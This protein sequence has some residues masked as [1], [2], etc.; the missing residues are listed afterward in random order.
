MTT[1]AAD[2]P[3]NGFY[4][5]RHPSYDELLPHW[6]FCQEAYLGG[7]DWFE[8]NLFRFMKEGEQE[9]KDRKARAIRIN[10]T[11]ETV[12]LVQKYLF[13][14]PV[15]RD[16]EDASSTLRAF[17][18]KSMRSGQGVDELMRLVSTSNSITGRI[19]LVVDNSFPSFDGN[20]ISRL[21]A[22]G[23]SGSIYA[24]IVMPQDILDYAWSDDDGELLWIKLREF[25]RDDKDPHES[26]GSIQERVRL[27]T[28]DS[29]ELYELFEIAPTGAISANKETEKEAR[30]IDSG[31]HGLGFVPV[32]LCDHS[33]TDHPFRAPGLVDDI[34]YIDRQ[35][36]NYMSDLDAIIQDQ[37]FSQLVVPSQ[38]LS[39]D[40]KT[41]RD[42][43]I[44]MGTNRIFSYD[45]GAGSNAKPE[46][47]SP[48]PKQAG[49]IT[50]T[51]NMLITQIYSTVGLAGERTKQDNAI[52]I[53]NSSGVAKAYDFQRVNSL[54]LAKA[55][56]LETA[57]N[58][59]VRTVLAWAGEQMP[60]ENLVTYPTTFD[61]ASLN[62]EL[63][64]A[65]ALQKV[66]APMPIRRMHMKKLTEKLMPQ[67]TDA[68][69]EVLMSS[70]DDW[71]DVSLEE[72]KAGAIVAKESSTTTAQT[73]SKTV[74]ATK[75]QGSVTPDTKST[76]KN[77]AK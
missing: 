47:I 60:K 1:A 35:V 66:Q 48:D 15:Q 51:I 22:S 24:Y 20:K 72:T 32:M 63:V 65:Q 19:A 18:N 64:T 33:T 75:R 26:D 43:L 49:V 31:V 4:F 58:W 23:I 6:L 53:D 55:K 12:D 5:R 62:D 27:W 68:E 71:N 21:E 9:F 11:R 77:S 17:W 67:V 36:N 69:W 44:A 30:M 29:W 70:I 46:Y 73:D 52:G 56:R 14:S 59:L 45:A 3:L 37:T 41:A 10:H 2:F 57:E 42:S 76:P 39:G 28:R 7:P 61:V 40:V 74:S 54:L 34:V 38:A 25:H 16:E 50:D 8:H 13:K